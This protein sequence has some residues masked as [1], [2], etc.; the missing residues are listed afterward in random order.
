MI[1]TS[2]VSATKKVALST[3][4]LIVKAGQS[5]KLKLKNNKK[6]VKWT[7]A[8]GKESISLKSKKNTGVTVVGKKKGTAK[9]QA[10]VGKKKYTCKVIVKAKETTQ[11]TKIPSPVVTAEPTRI[12]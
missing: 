9:E 12:L 8:S 5:K 3:K 1:P 11:T 10:K 4:K 2:E 6:K 7:V